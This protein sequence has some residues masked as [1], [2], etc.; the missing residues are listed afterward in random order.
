MAFFLQQHTELTQVSTWEDAALG[1]MRWGQNNS[2]PQT[3]VNLIA[4]SPSAEPAVSRTAKFYR[5]AG[6]EGEDTI[7][8]PSGITLKQVVSIMADDYAHFRAFSLQLN[9]NIKGEVT[10]IY[11]MRVATL[12]FNQFDE[13]NSAS[14]MGY[15]R[16]FGMN[17]VERKLIQSN[18]TRGNIK[19]FDR[20]NPEVVLDQIEA[21]EG[22]ISNYL[23]QILYYSEA[24]YN[25]YP[26]PPLQASIN[27]VLSDVE[28]SILVRKE[29]S[30]G[31]QNN[32]LLKT[33]LAAESPVLIA[34]ENAIEESQGARGSGR[35]VTLSDL[36]PEEVANNVLEEIGSGSSGRKTTIE[37]AILA[38]ELNKKIITGAYLIPP[39]LSGIQQANGMAGVDLEDA[40]SVFNSI[41]Q[42][43]RDLIEQQLNR[44]LAAS[45]FKVGPIKINKLSLKEEEVSTATVA[46][47]TNFT[48]MTG[49]QMQGLLRI[50]RNYNNKKTTY[51]QAAQL[52]KAGFGM[53]DEDIAI[54]LQMDEDETDVIGEQLN[55]K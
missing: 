24:G 7:V 46:T 5:G 23:G 16:N 30:T 19:W 36:S 8:A 10:A 17:A 35:I 52:L 55:H 53:E 3:L 9:Y 4:Q 49:K 15:H 21:T 39:I 47:K 18:P 13:L 20:F 1:I 45:K 11:P 38:E 12:R 51:E 31:F 32:Y 50:V 14:K 29:T 43:G 22:G 33:T 27:Y 37:A 2:Y 6:F 44:V 28:N 26:I 48:D 54:W 42:E 40:Y 25:S 41:T 34:L